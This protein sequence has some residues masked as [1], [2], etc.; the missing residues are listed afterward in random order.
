VFV[1]AL[2]LMV[3]LLA[4]IQFLTSGQGAVVMLPIAIWSGIVL[5]WVR[6]SARDFRRRHTAMNW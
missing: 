4:T 3:G 6:R 5:V 2:S 1:A